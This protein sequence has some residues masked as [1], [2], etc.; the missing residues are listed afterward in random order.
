M[1]DLWPEHFVCLCGNGQQ[2]WD[3]KHKSYSCNAIGCAK[4][5]TEDRADGAIGVWN[6]SAPEAPKLTREQA[7]QRAPE[8]TLGTDID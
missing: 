3:R 8:N 1:T 6:G 5:M 2:W 7:W 4:V